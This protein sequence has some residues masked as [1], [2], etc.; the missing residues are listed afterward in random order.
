MQEAERQE[1]LVQARRKEREV[2]APA[3]RGT[4]RSN[5]PDFR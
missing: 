5:K 4:G 2:M 3:D 1:Y